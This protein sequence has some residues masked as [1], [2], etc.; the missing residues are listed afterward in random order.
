MIVAILSPTATRERLLKDLTAGEYPLRKI[1]SSDYEFSIPDYQRP[2]AWGNE[3][4]LQLLDD[5]EGALAR[6]TDEPY[7]LGSIVLVKT[8]S[9]PKA[10]VIDG[11]QR[12][13]T[14]CILFAVMRDLTSNPQLAAELAKVVVE[15]GEILAGTSPKPRLTLRKRDSNFFADFVQADGAIEALI[16]LEDAHLKTDAQRAGSNSQD[17][18]T[19][20][21]RCAVSCTRSD[22]STT[23]PRH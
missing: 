23:R 3:Q 19:T 12:L 5:L 1:F 2:Y 16:G 8:G 20:F 6:D 9:D 18:W 4:A 10:E 13:T 21:F 17:L 22:R 11:Q 15:P 7:F 14:L